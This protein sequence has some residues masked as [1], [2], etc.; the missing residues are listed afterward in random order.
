MTTKKNSLL[1]ALYEISRLPG[2]TANA[3]SIFEAIL[4]CAMGC[5]TSD[6]GSINLID[7]DTRLLETEVQRGRVSRPSQFR[8]GMGEGVAG[9]VAL[10][11]RPLHV[12]DVGLSPYN[13]P[14][15]SPVRSEIAAPMMS[16]GAVIGVISLNS[17][18][19]EGFTQEDLDA[20]ARI[21]EEAARVAIAVWHMELLESK[22]KQLGAFVGTARELVGRLD[23]QSLLGQITDEALALCGCR[24][25]ALFLHDEEGNRL[26][27][28]AMS[29][30]RRMSAYSESLSLDE[31][32]LGTVLRR[33]KQVE[34]ADLASSDELHFAQVVREEGLVSMLASPLVFEDRAIGVLNIYT[35]RRHRF[36]NDERNLLSALC[37][38]SALSITNARLYER[39]FKTEDTLRRNDRL[40]TLGMLTA[41]IA[42]EIRN[43][44]TVIKL[45]FGSLNLDFNPSDMRRRDVEIIAEKLDQLEGIVT[46]VLSYGRNS[47]GL[48]SR[49]DLC[50]TVDDTL[51]LVRLKLRQSGINLNFECADEQLSV[52][53][54]KGQLQQALLNI[55]MNATQAMS[56]GG[57]LEVSIAKERSGSGEAGVIR[58]RD[59]GTGI[60]AHIRARIFDSFLTDKATGTGLGLNISKRI[61]KSHSGDI[62]IEKSD[63]SGTT[64]K[65]WLPL[66]EA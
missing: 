37:A 40:T 18:D 58:V 16:G 41:E 44:L 66:V 6:G 60:P 39:V 11:A 34:V 24:L 50:R 48:H 61:L 46:R 63:P 35:S 56:E 22:A 8:L 3:R 51:H 29:G 28:E 4:D 62:E 53:A 15:T 55:I 47:E 19:S 2:T 17:R 52:E 45:L 43:P 13:A 5:I 36:S 54:S 30:R 33:K 20:L 14:S 7:P 49:L 27:L 25:A 57:T 21:G 59:T 12:K 9:W 31:S 26:T 38:I 32:A 10:H 65:L 42:H 1:E 64:V 23:M